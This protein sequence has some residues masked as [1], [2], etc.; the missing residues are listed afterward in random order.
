[1][2]FVDGAHLKELAYTQQNINQIISP[3]R[4]NIYD[5]TGVAL[6][7]SAQVD[8]I[9]IN[10]TKITD[11]DEGKSKALKEKVAKG[12]SEI[13]ELDYE[14]VFAKVSSNSQVETIVKKVE[15]EKVDK[16]KAW[17]K[18]ND[19]SVGINIDA[20]TKR[21]YPYNNVASSVIGFCGNDNQGLT[22]IESTWEN[23]LTGTPRKNCKF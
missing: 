15:Q 8:T 10:P 21:Y 13:F 2:Q 11:K 3:K 5:S 23:V 20:D 7:I 1:M 14:E 19:I 18:E 17:M 9:T 12:L 22:G 6:A 4:G 16:L